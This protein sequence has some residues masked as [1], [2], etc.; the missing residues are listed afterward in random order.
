[1]F[2]FLRIAAF[3]SICFGF[4][5]VK[6]LS[7]EE[8]VGQ[9]LMVH[10]QGEVANA[11]A[12]TLIQEVHVGSIIY[13][14]WANGLRSF[15]QVQALSAGLQTLAQESSHS[16][17]LLIAADQEGGVVARLTEGFTVF[18]GNRALA[19]AGNLDFAEQCAYAM[20]QEMLSA[21]VNMNLAPVVDVNRNAQNPVIGIRSFGSDPEMVVSFGK[22][23]LDGYRRASIA[24][25]LKHF[26]GHGNVAIDSHEDLPVAYQSRKTLEEVELLPFLRLAPYADAVM[27]AHILVPALDPEHCATL[28]EKTLSYLRRSIGFQ[29]VILSD[30]LVM[31]GVLKKCGGSVD[32]AAIQ[33]FKAGCDLL[34]LG[35]KQLVGGSADLELTVSDVQR[36][37]GKIVDAVKSRRISEERL[38]QSVQRILKLKERYCGKFSAVVDFANHER[39]AQTIASLALQTIKN[40]SS[41]LESLCKSHVAVIAPKLLQGSISSLLTI[42]YKTDALFFSGLDPSAQKIEMIRE[43]AQS[44]DVLVVCS[45]NAWK[46]PMQQALIEALT[47]LDKPLILVATRDPQ[48]VELFPKANL[49]FTTFSPTAPSMQ[50]VSDQ[51]R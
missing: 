2:Q 44:A 48:D 50:A 42:G 23:A 19:A 39:L 43:S 22:R 14:N 34:I 5:T 51:L 37:H 33:A 47:A 11:D 45:Y 17:P 36:I 35:G 4:T 13:Y 32:E 8:K 7:L 16:I 28:S 25:C 12:K 10:F 1:M 26:P 41:C 9:I 49:I 40:D 30:S 20:G 29:G 31:Q 27:T 38:N 24:A 46:N 15:A 6:E 21:G 18:P 3:A